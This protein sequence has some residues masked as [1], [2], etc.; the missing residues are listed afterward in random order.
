MPLAWQTSY[1]Y[2]SRT[3][4]GAYGTLLCHSNVLAFS[5]RPLTAPA[6]PLCSFEHIAAHSRG[7]L[8][9]LCL[10]SPWV[11]NDACC[12]Y[13]H[14]MQQVVPPFPET[15]RFCVVEYWQRVLCMYAHHGHLQEV[16]P[17][18]EHGQG[19][20]MAYFCLIFWGSNT[21]QRMLDTPTY[22]HKG[23]LDSSFVSSLR[24]AELNFCEPCPQVQI[25]HANPHFV[26]NCM[27]GC[28][29]LITNEGAT[30]GL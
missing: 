8:V 2:I 11:G 15:V 21:S 23:I 13:T 12:M 17:A 25:L 6:R 27:R 20:K 26:V 7:V 28:R 5:M 29:R 1:F 30:S 4:V 3:A 19:K 10:L 24:S 16:N 18:G 9:A 22:I 14:A